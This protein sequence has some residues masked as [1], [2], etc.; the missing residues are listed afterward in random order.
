MGHG[1][2][3]WVFALQ[4]QIWP[5]TPGLCRTFGGRD[6]G[7]FV[8]ATGLHM[9]VCEWKTIGTECQYVLNSTLVS[10]MCHIC[11]ISK[12]WVIAADPM[13]FLK[14]FNFKESFRQVLWKLWIFVWWRSCLCFPGSWLGLFL[15]WWNSLF[16]TPSA[17]TQLS[18]VKFW[19]S[20]LLEDKGKL[21]VPAVFQL[22]GFSS[23]VLS[24]GR[25]RVDHGRFW[26]ESRMWSLMHVKKTEP[27]GDAEWIARTNWR[28]EMWA[29][30]RKCGKLK[31]R[32][33]RRSVSKFIRFK[34]E[35]KILIVLLDL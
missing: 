6:L 7:S 23:S 31:N 8:G 2:G 14:H 4:N 15:L 34:G 35:S 24:V 19:D 17:K 33:S 16:L 28:E 9:S 25:Y 26:R 21:Q 29:G 20:Q 30:M 1:S 32:Q 5:A 13:F 3:G 12:S 11:H 22:G 10:N 18:F 27:G